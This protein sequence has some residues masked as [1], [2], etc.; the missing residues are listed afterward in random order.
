MTGNVKNWTIRRA[1]HAD[2]PAL[3]AMQQEGWTTDYPGY[4]PEGYGEVALK[5]YGT[6]EAL[7][8][9]IQEYAYYFV[10][11]RDGTVVGAISGSHLNETET[12]VWWIHVPVVERGHGIGRAL[13]DHFKAHLP[14]AIESLYVTTFDGYIPTVTFYERVGFTPHERMVQEYDGVAVNDVRLKMAIRPQGRA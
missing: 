10:A 12:E 1:H 7:A 3:I 6:A 9:Q 5:R 14:P 13:I 4:M 11:E 8:K 2:I